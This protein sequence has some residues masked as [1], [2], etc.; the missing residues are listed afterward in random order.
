[1]DTIKKKTGRSMKEA[2]NKATSHNLCK[3]EEW[4]SRKEIMD[5]LEEIN[6]CY[7]ISDQ[8]FFYWVRQLY[9]GTLKKQGLITYYEGKHINPVLD[10][11]IAFK[12]QYSRR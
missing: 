3:S 4:Y 10:T 12:E 9:T 7:L 2:I 6:S 1:M 8:T 5:K 11:L